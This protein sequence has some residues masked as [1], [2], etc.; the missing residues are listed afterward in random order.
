MRLAAGTALDHTPDPDRRG[1]DISY[2]VQ[3]DSNWSGVA[4]GL[5]VAAF[6][7]YQQ[8]KLPPAL[9]LLL[10]RYA[11]DRTLAGAFMS[12]YALAGLVL[13]VALGRWIEQAGAR[14]PVA[15]ALALMAAGVI[16]TLAVPQSGATV[17]G[18]RALEGVG[19]A[20]LAIA[21]P[22]LANA[23]ASRRHLPVVISLT[24]AWIPIGQLVA[25]LA[26]Q[27]T[28]ALLGW[29]GLWWIALAMTAGL[30][31]ALAGLR[32]AR[33]LDPAPHANTP[34]RG[35]KDGH[36]VSRVERISLVIAAAVFMLWSGQYFAY[37]TWLPQYLIEAL[38]F[39]VS[40]AI[41][42]Y[43]LP[44]S[45]LLAAILVTGQALRRGVP[46]GPLLVAGLALQAGTW[47]LLPLAGGG[48]TGALA[49]AVYGAGAGIVPTCLFA[50]PSAIAGHGHAAASA[51]G[52][53]MTGRNLGVLAGPV[54]LAQVF[55]LTGGWDWAA[56][57]LGGVTAVALVLGA[58]LA[59][60]LAGV[61]YGTSR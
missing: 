5:L 51:F 6:A 47:V 1:S 12:V 39:S 23:N 17:L 50:M 21:G 16:L 42:G 20:I 35:A 15:L 18:A 28:F 19:F 49:L 11:Y 27:P 58:W 48:A 61:A 29:Q 53:I 33:G 32:S 59:R 14:R 37:M 52:I 7:A 41:A 45:M 22:V 46:V 3:R 55:A 4:F 2:M 36:T 60:R 24:A 56:P 43:S 38:G 34:R 26:A 31:I 30:V 57:L 54:G 8:F 9:P 40:G 44:V 10:E 25:V 13:S